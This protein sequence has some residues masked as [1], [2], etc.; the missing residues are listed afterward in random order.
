LKII[1]AVAK[2]LNQNRWDIFGKWEQ[3]FEEIAADEI[4]RLNRSL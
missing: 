1:D 3:L 4:D 2:K